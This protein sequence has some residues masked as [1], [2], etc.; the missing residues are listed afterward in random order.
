MVARRRA[1]V[2]IALSWFLVAGVIGSSVVGP[3]GSPSVRGPDLTASAFGISHEFYD[4]FNVPFSQYWD[5]RQALYYDA[6]IGAECFNATSIP[7]GLCTPTDPD[8]P[9]VASYPYTHWYPFV[10]SGRPGEPTV[11]AFVYAPYRVRITGAEVPSYTLAEPVY[12]PVQDATQAAGT[13]LE[14]DW[15]MHYIGLAE[16]A[17]LEAAGCPISGSSLDGYQLRSWINLTMDLQESKRLFRVPSTV[18]TAQAA[19]DWWTANTDPFCAIKKPAESGWENA[20]VALGG[21]Q[22]TVGKYDIM[23]GYEWWYAPYFSQISATVDDDGTTHVRIDHAAWGT[24]MLLT[25][26]FYWGPSSYK[27]N[28]LDSTRRLGW[29]GMEYPWYEEFAFQANVGPAS[30]SFTLNAA[31]SYHFQQLSDPGPNR[32][33]DRT[34]DV[35]Y[36]TWGPWLADYVNDFTR[37]H[38]VSELDRY[39]NPPYSTLH[40]TPGSPPYGTRRTFDYTPI[41]WDLKAGETMTMR[42]PTGNV[43]F[44]D[45]NRTPLSAL[46]H[47]DY[48]EVRAAM[49]LAARVPNAYGSWNPATNTLTVTGPAPTGGPVGDA[50]PDRVPGNADDRYATYPWPSINFTAAPNR[51]PTASLDPAVGTAIPGQDVRVTGSTADADGDALPYSIAWGDGSTTT[52]TTPAGGGPIAA[53]HAYSAV[54]GYTVTMTVADG[55]GGTAT[56]STTVS[57]ATPALLR[58]TTGI[59]IHPTFGVP[60]KVIVDGVS[61][62]EWATTWVKIAPGE[63]TVA[64]SDVWNLGTPDPVTVNIP[65]GGVAEVQARYLAYGWLRVVTD[66]PV[67]GTISVNGAPSD[68]WEVWRAV[69]PGSYTISFGSV[70]DFRPPVAETVTVNAEQ[71]TTVVGRYTWDGASPGPDPATYALLRVTTGL[72]TDPNAGAPSA[73]S[74]NGVVRDEWALTWVKIPPGTYTVSFGDVVNLGTPADVTFTL[75][76]GQT[77]EVAGIFQVHGWLRVDTSPPVPGTIFVN[78]LPYDD[79]Q[80]WQSMPPGT[81]KVSFGPVPGFVTPAAIMVDVAGGSLAFVTGA[82][83]SAPTTVGTREPDA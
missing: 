61:R 9:D 53:E 60:G 31:I 64:F 33:Y 18:T 35:P 5:M 47:S 20:M 32:L 76:A 17:A 73:I 8:V 72:S 36:W 71:L 24:E 69:P 2:G 16:G 78:G 29:W 11:V 70:R 28:V 27:D 21:S 79:W 83:V 65:A 75:A 55:R 38:P 48:V 51:A 57:V 40:T 6:P 39:P 80:V 34:D 46:P 3:R 45:P 15:K 62:D 49:Q 74:V 13:R 42:Y 1:I 54:G 10:G 26:F 68:D 37:T 4:F 30:H 81:Y 19:R 67:P 56:A 66:P 7:A 77:R 25:R 44:Y 23:N 82:Y 22:T 58:V 41:A 63:H 50:G 14:I 43:V 52:G 59:D 12:I